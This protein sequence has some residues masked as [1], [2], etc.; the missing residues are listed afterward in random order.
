VLRAG[1]SGPAQMY[2]YSSSRPPRQRRISCNSVDE[3]GFRPRTTTTEEMK[4]APPRWPKGNVP[5]GPRVLLQADPPGAPQ[6]APQVEC[7]GRRRPAAARG[8]RRAGPVQQE[9]AVAR[10]AAH[11]VELQ[12]DVGFR[13]AAPNVGSSYTTVVALPS[14]PP[15]VI[16]CSSH[17]SMS[18]QAVAT[19]PVT[20]LAVEALA[21][22]Q[23]QPKME[24]GHCTAI[25]GGAR[26]HQ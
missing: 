5:P 4:R 12:C 26:M 15:D 22:C 20:E 16:G 2:T 24:R 19:A 14:A 17:T 9:A 13:T 10:G 7:G 6:A 25:R 8:Q 1:L 18:S 3:T 21:V 11:Q 23:Y